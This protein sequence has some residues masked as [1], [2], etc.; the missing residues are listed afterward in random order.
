MVLD[1]SNASFL[2]AEEDKGLFFSAVVEG[3]IG[4]SSCCVHVV[5][6][7]NITMLYAA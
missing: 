4:L 3:I 1:A 5:M 2:Y 7:I 6:N